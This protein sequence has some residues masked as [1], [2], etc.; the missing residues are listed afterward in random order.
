M[1]TM[2]PVT[3]TFA[4]NAGIAFCATAGWREAAKRKRQSEK[5]NDEER[6]MAQDLPHFINCAVVCSISSAAVMTLEFIS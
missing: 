1:R 2:S 6:I 3:V 5:S 4:R